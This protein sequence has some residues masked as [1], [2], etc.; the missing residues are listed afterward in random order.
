M[1]GG[2]PT[3]VRPPQAWDSSPGV[4]TLGG[5]YSRASR[6]PAI[7]VDTDS[8]LAAANG[9]PAT[10]LAAGSFP[11]SVAV[12]DFDGDPESAGDRDT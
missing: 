4:L 7:D 11:F 5:G 2:L 9:G 8:D 6:L 10:N 3:S 12:G 1:V